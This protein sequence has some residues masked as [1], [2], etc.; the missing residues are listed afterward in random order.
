MNRK[1]LARTSSEPGKTQTINYYNINDALYFVDLPGYGYAKASK[2]TVAKWGKMIEDYLT[3]SK[4]LQAVFLLVDIRH[5][6]SDNDR[7][8]FDWICGAGFI[9]IIVATKLDKI[10]RS[11]LSK[12]LSIIRK[13]LH[14][15]EGVKIIPFSALTK[16]GKEDIYAVIDEYLD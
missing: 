11:Q 16:Q 14:A 13:G 1:K 5:E 10:R 9:P 12:Q 6:P 3:F 8:M 4:D 2:E 15:G 7:M